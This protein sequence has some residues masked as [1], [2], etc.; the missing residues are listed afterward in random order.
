MRMDRRVFLGRMAGAMCVAPRVLFSDQPPP[1]GRIGVQLYTL[2]AEMA[3]DAEGTLARV[4]ALGYREVEFAG[5][6]DQTPQAVRMMLGRN[7]LTSPATHIDYASVT[8]RL[9]QVI[10]ASQTIGHRFIVMPWLDESLRKQSDVWKRVAETL[11]RAGELTAKAGIRMTYHNHHF[12]FA[13]GAGGKLPFDELLEEC[14]P[15]LVMFELDLAWM[16]AAGQDPLAY[17][18]KYPGRFPLVHVKGLKKKPALGATTP[19]EQVL[20]D[21]ADVGGDAI[22]WAKILPVAQKAGVHHFFVE[23]DQPASA[24][25]SL[26][27]SFGYLQTLKF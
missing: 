8:S 12:E 13:P 4:A 3:K 19:I 6:F 17:F 21:I 26:K 15:K 14:D 20:P 2:R 25:D 1:I 16:T 5:Y 24:F 10:E 22:E 11:N 9:P 18:G 27:A 7:G 23:H